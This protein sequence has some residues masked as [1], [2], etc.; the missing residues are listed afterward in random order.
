MMGMRILLL[1]PQPFFAERGTPIAVRALLEVLGA[2]GC[3]INVVTYHCGTDIEIPNVTVHRIRRP[4]LVRSVPI[5]PSWQKLACDLFLFRLAK[6]LMHERVY[7]VVHAVE[8]A[9]FIARWLCRSTEVRYVYDMDSLMSAQILE[10]APLLR[11]LGSL[12]ASWEKKA[13]EDSAGVLAVCPALVE[14]ALKHHPEGNVH[15]L[16][17]LPNTGASEGTLPN[18]IT[19]SQGIRILYVGNLE[20]YQGIGL[21]LEAFAQLPAQTD[22]KA[23]LIIVGGN[24]QDI[25]TYTQI[26][27]R[28]GISRDV[29]FTGPVPVERLSLVLAHADIL[30]SPRLSGINT[31]M[32]IYSYLQSGKPI[33]ATR[34]L[35]HT[36]VLREEVA[37]LV[38]PTAED[39]ARGLSEL[40]ASESRRRLLGERGQQLVEREY[41]VE[42]FTSRLQTFYQGLGAKAGSAAKR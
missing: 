29:R 22:R 28:L 2:S 36:Q 32:K 31:P 39:M 11:P 26:C 17:D 33:V 4:P 9:V 23:T 18:E 15:L 5:G 30:V 35:T 1:A 40:I 20:A 19:E 38:D 12:L 3:S 27:T 42:R 41:G 16:P 8:E 13:I 7:D 24:Q 37:C 21:L 10:K 6:K 14:I 25:L 34:L